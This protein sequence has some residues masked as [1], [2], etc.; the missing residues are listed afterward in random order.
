MTPDVEAVG[1]LV[2]AW[3]AWDQAPSVK[4]RVVRKQAALVAVAGWGGW[5]AFARR[6]EVLRRAGVSVR[7]AITQTAEEQQRG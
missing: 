6:V 3:E 4:N 7:D 1:A 2:G 5:L